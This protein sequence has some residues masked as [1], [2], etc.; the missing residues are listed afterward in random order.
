[1]FPQNDHPAARAHGQV[2]GRRGQTVTG[3]RGKRY[4]IRRRTDQAGEQRPQLDD[5]VLVLRRSQGPGVA[6]ARQALAAGLFDAG[7]AGGM[8]GAVDPGE[9]IGNI[10]QMALVG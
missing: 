6:F 10:E 1:M 5:V 2:I 4:I 8:L 9:I 3:G 7:Q